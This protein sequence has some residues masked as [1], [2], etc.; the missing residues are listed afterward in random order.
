VKQ[1]FLNASQTAEVVEVDIPQCGP[2]DVLI[3][4]RA[5]LISTGTETAGYDAG[6]LLARAV[7]NP[8]V[9]GRVLHSLATEGAVATGRKILAKREELLPLG[10]SGAGTVVATGRAVLGLARGDRVAYAGAAHAEY[11]AVNQQLLAVIPEGV[12]FEAAAFGGVGC[13]ALHG[14]RLA[15]P[16]LGETAVVVGLGLIGLL[17]AQ[18]ARASG[19]RVIG[20]EPLA[21]RREVAQSL[22][23]D[24]VLDPA[25]EEDLGRTILSLTGGIGADAV[26]LCAKLQAS[27]VTNASLRYAR[28]RARVVMIGDMGLD[29]DRGPLFAKELNL[30]VSRSYGPGR[31]DPDYECKGLDYPVGYVRWTEGRNLAQLMTMLG[32]GTLQVDRMISATVGIAD[33]A[34]GYQRLVA[35]PDSALAV[36]LTYPSKSA[37]PPTP[38]PVRVT[39]S[40]PQTGELRIG[41][42]GAGSFVESN[43]L[44]HLSGLG[45]RLHAV[46][47]RGNSAFSRL[48]AVYQPSLLTTDPEEL[49]A[50]PEVDAVI[51]GTRH[52]SHAALAR[53]AV[54]AGKPVQV[55]K[56]LALTLAEADSLARLVVERDAMLTIGYNR[57]LAPTTVALREVLSGLPGPKQFLYRINAP[58]LPPEH[59]TLDPNEGGGRLVGEGCH[60]IDL[61]CYLAGSEVSEVSG[62]FVGGGQSASPAQDNFTLTLRFRGGDLATIVYTGQGNPGLEK[63]RLEVF[64]AGKAFVLDNFARLLAYGTRLPVGLPKREDKG[65]RAHLA[66]FLGAVRGESALVT[67]VWDGVRVARIIQQLREGRGE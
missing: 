65:F 3:A 7:R 26:L 33:A 10:Y 30:R 13:I 16:T 24:L 11:V 54:L 9:V 47:N 20:I 19:M 38:A 39:A 22:G 1:V 40:R 8:S 52:D 32:D 18:C 55:E 61:V 15:E 58:L 4:A 49:L 36:V 48:R 67:T 14:V 29:L 59:W 5:S 57:R 45:A 37:E 50:D 2:Q 6:G 31:Y 64:A 17:A 51:I 12:S 60:F 63:E 62:G 35:S 41:V 27:E 25:T 56:P 21:H 46:A 66:S 23:L 28:D 42:I 53:A 44:P 43:L 34:T